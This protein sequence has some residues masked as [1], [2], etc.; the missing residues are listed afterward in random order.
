MI[1]TPKK[2][3]I[4]KV[5][6]RYIPL[7]YSDD[8]EDGFFDYTH[9][10]KL[11]F[12]PKVNRKAHTRND[13][14]T[15]NHAEDWDELTKGLKIGDT[16][17]A[18]PRKIFI[19]IMKKYW[20]C[21]CKRP[22]VVQSSGTK[23]QLT[24]EYSHLCVVKCQGTDHR[25]EWGA[26]GMDWILM[27]PVDDKESNKAANNLVATGECN[28]DLEKRSKPTTS[29]LWIAFVHRKGEEITLFCRRI[30]SWMLG[31]QSK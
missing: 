12:K 30:L 23:S 18:H 21:L 4:P 6:K 24:P 11:V 7:K 8:I 9:Y 19:S 2:I 10:G 27:Q 17:S 31:Y 22:R 29:V 1:D 16:V 26:E 14:I 3:W 5:K 15:Y 28:F 25:T 20:D 13:I